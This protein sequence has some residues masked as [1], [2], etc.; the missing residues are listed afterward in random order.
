MENDGS[1]WFWYIL[2]LYLP[3]RFGSGTCGYLQLMPLEKTNRKFLGHNRTLNARSVTNV[4]DPEVLH[5][6][7]SSRSIMVTET[8]YP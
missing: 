1:G 7:V 3:W 6:L 4:G 5:Q 8:T 2:M